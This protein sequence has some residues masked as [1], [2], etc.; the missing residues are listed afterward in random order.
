MFHASRFDIA[1]WE[2]GVAASEGFGIGRFLVA[3][4][5]HN[6]APC[7][8]ACLP[9]CL[10]DIARNPYPASFVYSTELLMQLLSDFT[11]ENTKNRQPLCPLC[12]CGEICLDPLLLPDLTGCA[13]LQVGVKA[14]PREA[15]QR[16]RLA[17]CLLR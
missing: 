13:T 12:L 15:Q 9:A 8:L 17:R 4:T 7:L 6:T 3:A 1:V 10:R 16:L 11:I 14:W 5:P 2:A